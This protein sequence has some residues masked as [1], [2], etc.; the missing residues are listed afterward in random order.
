MIA[1]GR[2]GHG[3]AKLSADQ[4]RE[5]RASSESDRVLGERFGVDRNNISA[6]RRRE[7]W[8]HIA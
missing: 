7:T 4:V 5:I 2:H 1:R 8:K 3:G 6:I